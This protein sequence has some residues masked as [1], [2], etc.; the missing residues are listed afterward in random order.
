MMYLLMNE[1]QAIHGFV[2]G[3][4]QGVG[5]RM[6]T[7]RQARTLDLTGWVRNCYDG[8][9]EFYACG[10]ETQLSDFKQWLNRGPSMAHVLK[11]EVED[12][13]LEKFES[14]EITKTN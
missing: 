4:V 13:K 11:L 7:E 10:S 5:F 6:A 12:A 3:R 2:T 14:F 8:R 1:Q 9:V